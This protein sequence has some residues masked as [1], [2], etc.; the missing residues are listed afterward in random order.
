M[1]NRVYIR[2]ER[3][4]RLEDEQKKLIKRCCAAAA[5]REGLGSVEVS[6]LIT[7]DDGIRAI[8]LEQRGL[9]KPTDVLSFP[10]EDDEPM[11]DGYT[12]L[13]DIVLSLERA[14]EQAQQYGHSFERELAF[15]TVHGMLHLCGHD[16]ETG[17]APRERMEAAQEE[18]LRALGLPR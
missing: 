8:N 15:L 10:V 4:A 18:I 17:D 2:C 5:K 12:L 11:G 1:K 6:L 7:D 14:R 9:D 3:G 16:H 13:G